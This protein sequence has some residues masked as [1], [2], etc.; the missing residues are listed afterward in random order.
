MIELTLPGARV[1]F[2][3]RGEGD[4]REQEGFDRVRELAGR[5]LAVGRQVHGVVVRRVTEPDPP[6]QEADGQATARTDV[7][8]TVFVADCL[9]IAIAGDGV[10]AMLH[11]GWR[12]LAAGIVDEGVRAVR[13][14]GAEGPLSAAMGAG[15]RQCCYEVGDDVRAAFGTADRNLD[16]PGIAAAQLRAAGVEEILDSGV[17]TICDERF[18]SHR[19]EGATAGRQAGV[20]WRD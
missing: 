4:V 12:G 9:A 5:P 17:C 1:L 15:A 2:T 14:L 8:P 6:V 16:M 13:E 20:V 11:G 3:A 19:R 10:V 7:A 18:F